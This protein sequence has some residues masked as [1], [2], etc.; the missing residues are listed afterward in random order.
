MRNSLLLALVVAL[1][2]AVVVLLR[3]VVAAAARDRA[4]G[5]GELQPEGGLA[6]GA[7]KVRALA[8]VAVQALHAVLPS[9]PAALG[10]LAAGALLAAVRQVE[11]VA[12][13]RQPA[14]PHD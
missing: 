2:L 3:I 5:R 13:G 10:G 9:P 6:L 4:G 7:A 11:A 12:V 14:A 8:A 1:L